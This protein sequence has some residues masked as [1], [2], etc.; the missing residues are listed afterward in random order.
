MPIVGFQRNNLYSIIIEFRLSWNVS[1]CVSL[2]LL[3][4]VED[5]SKFIVIKRKSNPLQHAIIMDL[6]D[7]HFLFMS[8]LKYN[9]N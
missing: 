2:F 4:P 7:F 6:P 3:K 8:L 9:N 5:M 1:A